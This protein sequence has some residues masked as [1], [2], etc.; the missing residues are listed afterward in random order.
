MESVDC[1]STGHTQYSTR[2]HPDDR[3]VSPTRAQEIRPSAPASPPSH[4]AHRPEQQA[5]ESRDDGQSCCGDEQ[6][7]TKVIVF[8]VVHDVKTPEKVVDSPGAVSTS[9]DFAS[10]CIDVDVCLCRVREVDPPRGDWPTAELTGVGLDARNGT[11]RRRPWLIAL[12]DRC[13]VVP[14][15]RRGDCSPRVEPNSRLAGTCDDEGTSRRADN[16]QT[17]WCR[18]KRN[19]G[20]PV[21]G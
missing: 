13:R 17:L 3:P 7:V 1:D 5:G 6:R 19:R 20:P 8:A 16:F 15:D 2:S 4:E 18:A 12:A 10:P 11:H 21:S 9:R 14:V